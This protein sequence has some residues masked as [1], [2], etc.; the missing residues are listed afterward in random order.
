M[1]FHQQIRKGKTNIFYDP[2]SEN[3]LSETAL[4]YIGGLLYHAPALLAFTNP[5]TNSYRRLVPGYEAPVNAFFSRGN[6]SAAIRIPKYATNPD[7]VRFEFRPPD[8]TCNPY[9]AMAAMLMAGIDGIIHKISPKENGFGPYDEDIFSWTQEERNKIKKL[10][11]TLE[12]A[13]ISLDKDH[14]FLVKNDVFSKNLIDLWISKKMSEYK[15][16][17]IR[18]HPYE[19]ET[20]YDF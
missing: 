4:F 7:E 6:R 18:P 1:H 9:L 17:Q 13:L 5:S 16:V 2:E 10:P 15:E 12:E 8:A 3:L 11:S 19:I 20:Y 14:D